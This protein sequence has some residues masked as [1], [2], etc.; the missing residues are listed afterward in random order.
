MIESRVAVMVYEVTGS[1]ARALEKLFKNHR[2]GYCERPEVGCGECSLV[3]YGLDCRNYPVA[4]EYGDPEEIVN[5]LESQGADVW[6]GFECDGCIEWSDDTGAGYLVTLTNPGFIW[7]D[8][9]KRLDKNG[10]R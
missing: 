1:D 9:A 2:K 5:L 7:S 3:N 10:G 6:E 4:M 8:K